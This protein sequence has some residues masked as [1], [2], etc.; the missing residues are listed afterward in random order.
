MRSSP[1]FD[2]S[3]PPRYIVTYKLSGGSYESFF[4]K[5]VSSI[6]YSESDRGYV[7]TGSSLYEGNSIA[8]NANDPS[9]SNIFRRPK[10]GTLEVFAF[11]P[12]DKSV[13]PINVAG[14]GSLTSPGSGLFDISSLLGGIRNIFSEFLTRLINSFKSMLESLFVPSADFMKFEMAELIDVANKKLF[15]VDFANILSRMFNSTPANALSFHF[16]GKT[17]KFYDESFESLVSLV[18]S[19][20][21]V[22]LYYRLAVYH[23]RNIMS[24]L[25]NSDGG[26]N[27]DN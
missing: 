19:A 20:L 18:R 14:D 21:F 3:S 24:V 2:I 5:D 16:A 15:F 9:S 17:Y 7:Y 13:S 4:A 11:N 22:F 1:H 10:R 27:N 12:T 23:Y 26:L 8:Y 6:V 25:R